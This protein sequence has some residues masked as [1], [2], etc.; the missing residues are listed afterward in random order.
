M[1]PFARDGEAMKKSMERQ[2][3]TEPVVQLQG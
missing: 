3:V 2:L 1:A